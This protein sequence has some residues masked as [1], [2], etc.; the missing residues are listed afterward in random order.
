MSSPAQEPLPGAP[1]GRLLALA[2]L[3]AG[4][5]L[6]FSQGWYRQLDLAALQ[7]SRSQLVA[8]R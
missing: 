2:L 7:A 5:A 3:L 6:F 8:W 1:L 4:V